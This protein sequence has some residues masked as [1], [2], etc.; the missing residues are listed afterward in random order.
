[1]IYRLIFGLATL[2]NI[3]FGI[4]ASFWPDDLFARL[5]MAPPIYP[6]LWQCLGMVIGLYGVLYAYA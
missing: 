5:K 3:A 6:S 2:Y 1:M 4:W